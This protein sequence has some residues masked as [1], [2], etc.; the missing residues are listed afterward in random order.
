[1][2]RTSLAVI[3]FHHGS[4]GPRV[5]P[6]NVHLTL[7]SPTT[8]FVVEVAW[9]ATNALQIWSMS[10]APSTGPMMNP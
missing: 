9:F 3:C 8:L 5:I 1:M 10:S 4:S 7:C 6:N 2:S